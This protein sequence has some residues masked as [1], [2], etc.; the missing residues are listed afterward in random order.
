M[1]IPETWAEA[2]PACVTQADIPGAAR[3]AQQCQLVAHS[4]AT[5]RV[6][7]AGTGTHTSSLS[8]SGSSG[9][10]GSSATPTSASATS[11]TALPTLTPFNYGQEPIRGVNL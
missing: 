9:T 7:S 10:A 6:G 3:R 11:V 4:N 8:A 1:H 2:V 5:A